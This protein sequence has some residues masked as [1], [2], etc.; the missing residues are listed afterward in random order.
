MSRTVTVSSPAMPSLL[1]A[2]AL[3]FKSLEGDEGLGRLFRYAIELQTPDSASL[4]EYVTANVPIKELVG[5]EFSVVIELDG[6][7]AG[8]REINGLVTRA[9]FL[10]SEERRAIYEVV[11]EPWLVLATR[12]SDYRIF[13]NMT[14]LAIVR[15]VLADYGF[16]VEVR[17]SHSY[18]QRIFQVQYGEQDFAFVS[19]LMEEFGIYYFFEHSGGAHRMVLV[20][21]AG[22]H[23]P[24]ASAAYQTIRFQA[25]R[26][27]IDEEYCKH[28]DVTDTLASG[29][30]V[31]DDFDFTR[32][33]A[34]LQQISKMPR[35][36]G[37]NQ[38]E[39]Y[40]WP[41]D[42]AD[43]EEGRALARVRM[44]EAGAVGKRANGSG[45]LR[46]IVPGC[47]FKLQHH[48]QARSNREWLVIE[49]TLQLRESGHASGADSYF[50]ETRFHVQPAKDTYRSP[51]RH[52]KPRTS[53]PQTAIVTGPPG[54]EIWTNEYGQ[55]KLSFHW[56]RYCTKDQNSSCWV[57]V[58]YPWAGNGF[59][60]IA[61]PR[62]GQEVIVDFENGDPDRPIVSGRVYNALNMPPWELPANATQSG[63]LTRSSMHGARGAG[64]KNGPGDANALRFEDR[65]GQEQLWLHAQKDQLTEVE[66]DEDKWVGNDR[67][68]TVDRDETSVIHRD[69]TETVDHDETL[70]IHNDRHERVDG[71]EDVSIGG[72]QDLRV[73]KAKTETIQRFSIQNVWLA[74]ME[75][76]GLAYNRNVGAAMATTVGLARTDIV[77]LSWSQ[78]IG[79]NYEI[80]VAD[81][82]SVTC[83]K[84]SLKMTKEG[85]IDL[86]GDKIRINGQ[87]LTDITGGQSGT[88]WEDAGI[89]HETPGRSRTHAA[90]HSLVGPAAKPS[91]LAPAEQDCQECKNAAQS[92]TG[93]SIS[94]ARG[95]ERLA[96]T[97]FVLQAPLPITWTRSYHSGFVGYDQKGELGARWVTPYT[98]A[99]HA[100]GLEQLRYLASDGRTHDYPL[101]AVGEVHVDPIE[102]LLLRRTGAA[103]LVIER[104]P[105]WH[106]VFEWARS[107]W[108]PI[109]YRT[110][111]G[112]RIEMRYDEER[113][114]AQPR[115]DI[116]P[117]RPDAH[118]RPAPAALSKSL[119][120]DVLSYQGETLVAHAQVDYE[121]RRIAGVWEMRNGQRT[122]QLAAYRYDEAG[123]LIQA[124]DENALTLEEAAQAARHY[125]YSHHLLTRYTD[126]TGR[127]MNLQWSGSAEDAKAGKAR[128]VR[129]WADDGSF[130]T[131]LAWSATGA[132]SVTDALGHTTVHHVDR[133]GYTR[134]IDHPDGTIERLKRDAA[135]N[136]TAHHHPDGS[137][138][139]FTYQSA[140]D[141]RNHL[142]EHIRADGSRIAYS[143]DA[144]GRLAGIVDPI[145][146]RWSRTYTAAGLLATQTDALGRVTRHVY[147]GKNQLVE[148]ID[149]K[150]ASK[151][152][153]YTPDGQLASF[154]D[155]SG[156]TSRWGYDA[157]GRQQATTD[158]AGHKTEYVYEQGQLAAIVH[159]D[160]TETRLARDAEGRLL[161]HTDPLERRTEY[162]YNKAGLIQQ[163]IQGDT[164]LRY[165]WDKLARL[166]ALVNENGARYGFSYDPMGRLV[167]ERD[168]DKQV[169]RYRHQPR[170]VRQHTGHWF[171]HHE[172]DPMGR[173]LQRRAE[174][175]R[176]CDDGYLRPIPDQREQVERFQYDAAGRVVAAT[177]RDARLQWFYDAVGNVV[178]EHQ[179][180]DFLREPPCHVWQHEYDEL[181]QRIATV[182]SNGSRQQW[183]SYG[184]G[185]VHGL[186]L[187][188]EELVGF[189][190]DA[191]HRET[192]RIQGN[193]LTQHSVYDP[194][195]RLKLQRY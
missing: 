124:L 87:A 89:T 121:D 195:G 123:D 184:S 56:N 91:A 85:E 26:V 96:H 190:R 174:E 127:A 66:H 68:K 111:Q 67:R 163:R 9:R 41:G 125:R 156:H 43:A 71:N 70:T 37:N 140:A 171:V 147:D 79:R 46:A 5:K 122:R 40:R 1:G 33:K 57:R 52:E 109:G 12:T 51:Q 175:L 177:N 188:G 186:M 172:Y 117:E 60:S 193:G 59:G 55:V 187:D 192:A 78:S 35:K 152:L 153:T 86:S 146:G 2:S 36:T 16:P 165:E 104:G 75:N 137:V 8:T 159:P 97:D 149:P 54:Q 107:W 176:D 191:L 74:R 11:I 106:E 61:I 88:K 18:P 148:I 93:G 81:Q 103:E 145:G 116:I 138:E 73:E 50:C 126:R 108:R 21:D 76:V 150:G 161:A 132:A 7:G 64:L 173:L 92:G 169:T 194:A 143:W 183:L 162:R 99:L 94:F 15:E 158:A 24:F 154:T 84:A 167:E 38:Q 189:E 100:L 112:N 34:K 19:R 39:M 128:A 166:S 131:R 151:K 80:T 135:Y 181:D 144:Q 63:V 90:Q 29:A 14:P 105:D 27:K 118:A 30:W 6:V 4:S 130:D 65:K 129:E 120:S 136:V 31:T 28:F 101:P 23:Q 139:H 142:V 13:Q 115:N 69:R 155:C 160:K 157:Q 82:F 3:E 119:L 98:V 17:V 32:P 10:R 179:H 77:G 164:I 25:E 47:T 62:I 102:E 182:R 22:A 83:G 141:G 168:F 178:R 72:N 134:Q 95:S 48:P 170:T 180:H 49:A 45:N 185:H 110:P 58:S 20:D 42:Y 114:G 53:G 113:Q 44:E 133:L